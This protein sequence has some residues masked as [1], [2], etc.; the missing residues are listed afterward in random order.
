MKLNFLG[1][2]FAGNNG[3]ATWEGEVTKLKKGHHFRQDDD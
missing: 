1:A 2:E 3:Q